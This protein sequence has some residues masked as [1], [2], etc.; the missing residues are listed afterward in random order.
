MTLTEAR[1]KFLD[2]MEIKNIVICMNGT[3]TQA[4]TR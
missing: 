4:E 3:L 1:R 2:F